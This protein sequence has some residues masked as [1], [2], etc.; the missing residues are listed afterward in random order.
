MIGKD[1]E[2]LLQSAL[3]E[4]VQHYEE[5][6]TQLWAELT[7]KNIDASAMTK[8][9][10][11]IIDNLKL[12]IARLCLEI[13]HISRQRLDAQVQE[14]GYWADLQQ[15]LQEQ[16]LAQSLLDKIQ[17]EVAWENI[18]GW[19]KMEELEQQIADLTANLRMRHQFSH[20][21]E[22]S[23]AQLFAQGHWMQTQ[24][25]KERSHILLSGFPFFFIKF[26]SFLIAFWVQSLNLW[27]ISYS[28][29]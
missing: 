20:D 15:R 28:R 23:N 16:S 13:D 9:E 17:E 3:K 26:S 22:L 7:A 24:I 2:A 14:A 4:Q 25:S 19:M 27:C 1:Y 5:E 29:K 6:I 11:E 8:E 12:D 18:E 21:K 10:M